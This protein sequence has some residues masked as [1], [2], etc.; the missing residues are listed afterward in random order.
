MQRKGWW[1]RSAW[2]QPEEFYTSHS[3]SYEPREYC[4]FFAIIYLKFL[5]GASWASLL[6][7]YLL[8]KGVLALLFKCLFHL[9]VIIPPFSHSLLVTFWMHTWGIL[10]TTQTFLLC[11]S[12]NNLWKE[13]RWQGALGYS[14]EWKVTCKSHDF[15]HLAFGCAPC[16]FLYADFEINGNS[17]ISKE[18]VRKEKGSRRSWNRRRRVKRRSLLPTW[19][20]LVLIRP[21]MVNRHFWDM[22]GNLSKDC[23]LGDTET[24][25]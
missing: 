15:R 9:S 1:E 8:S 7:L 22:Q 23:V 4:D 19:P 14:H 12:Q 21:V 5:S 20:C 24:F 18:E 10:M 3:K 17:W 6:W 13:W 11:G 25:C 16:F 2:P